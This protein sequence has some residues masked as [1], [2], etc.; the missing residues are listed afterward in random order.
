[1][2]QTYKIEGMHCA[3]CVEKIRGV[4]KGL[5]TSI[6]V[7]LDPPRAVLESTTV[8][9]LAE[10]N[11]AVEKV[12]TY[13]LIPIVDTSA[14]STQ[15]DPQKTWLK[16]YYPLFLIV[17]LI[18]VVSFRGVTNIH[19]WMLHFMAGFFIVFGFFKLLDVK[20]FRDAYATYDLLAKRWNNYGLI[21]PFLEIGLGLAFLFQVNVP[22][23]LWFSA[24]LMG[25]SSLGVIKALAEKRKI[26]CACLGTVLN[27]PMSTITLVEDL[28][29][30]AMSAWMLWSILVIAA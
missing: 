3:S 25:F 7:T 27:L 22:M 13:K 6:S 14:I 10:L 8:L 12:G 11:K 9:D 28:G 29:M 19:D 4:L 15:D 1:M 24:I 2:K 17:G 26:R 23:T 20:G 5:A 18:V 21:Y 30:V 16:T